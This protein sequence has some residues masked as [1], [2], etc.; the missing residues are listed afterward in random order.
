MTFR[1]KISS[2]ALALA[3]AA[4]GTEGGRSDYVNDTAAS[5]ATV[6][7]PDNPGAPDSTAGM[8]QRTGAPGAAGTRASVNGDSGLRSTSPASSA[9]KRP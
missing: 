4:C 5:P 8:S 3:L 9:P 7:T 2:I 1:V 6:P